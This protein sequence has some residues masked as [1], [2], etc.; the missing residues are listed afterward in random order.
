MAQEVE[1]DLQI[2]TLTDVLEK[3]L[4]KNF[5]IRLSRNNVRIADNNNALGNAGMLPVVSA[6][7][8]LSRSSQNT[9]QEFASG[10]TQSRDGASRQ[11]VNAGV[12]MTWTLFDGTRMFAAMNR[13]QEEAIQSNLQLKL[14]I[15]NTL[16]QTMQLYYRVAFEQE[17]LS[18][19]QSNVSF[20]E[21]R[22]RI[23]DEKYKV[24]KE[25]KM[26]L[27]QAQVDLNSDR[28][29]LVQQN[30]LLT[31]QKLG[32]LRLMGVEPIAFELNHQVLID[33][34]LDLQALQNQALMKNPLLLI[35]SSNS[36]IQNLQIQELN[37]SRMPQ[38]D[39]NLGYGYSNLES[40]AGFL[41]RNQ[42]FDLNYGLSARV[43]LFTGFNQMRNIQNAQIQLENN[44]LLQE[45]AEQLIQS[46]LMT[47][48]T[49]YQNN[50][51]L[52]SLEKQNLAVAEENSQIALERFRLG[53]SDALQLREAQVNSVNAQIR[54]LQAQY[55]AKIAEIELRRL[56]GSLTD[57]N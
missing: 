12:N 19:F 31:S 24:G 26:S 5:Q 48:Y 30:E 42:T 57:A 14:Q 56:S 25:S 10:D 29:S 8:A 47:F 38:L 45:E 50:R 9:E 4:E 23:V 41:L 53:V 21:E 39:L 40:E 32:L 44:Q 18:L 1:T 34:T 22:V 49:T 28:S 17:R 15:D 2:L 16:S 52:L 7:G 20:S 37:R 6:A 43:N 11:L 55:N 3:T 46:D 54:F 27:L 35:Q 51:I 36:E 13:L 33:T